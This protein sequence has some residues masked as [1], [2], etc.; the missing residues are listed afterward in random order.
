MNDYL[1][2]RLCAPCRTY[3]KALLERAIRDRLI[4]TAPAVSC[5]ASH[6][7]RVRL[8]P[9]DGAISREE[10]ALGIAGRRTRDIAILS[11]VGKQVCFHVLGQNADST[12]RLSRVSAQQEA[13]DHILQ[14]PAGTIV[15]AV[16]TGL[17]PFGAF[18]DIGCGVPA[19]LPLKNLCISRLSHPAALLHEGQK[20]YAALQTLDPA[21]RRVSISMKELLGT[22]QENAAR[23]A[24]GQ[25][26]LGI[27]RGIQDYGAFIALTPN[28]CGLTGPDPRLREGSAVSVYIRSID[29]ETLR[30]RL[31]VISV[32]DAPAQPQPLCFT[33]TH[34]RLTIWQYGNHAHAKCL[35]IF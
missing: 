21:R 15:P 1:P 12:Y 6:T 18:A 32:L 30:I 25:T 4:L 16:V 29:P 20:I 8:G 19:L 2:E 28:L 34:G 17:A 13:L 31:N 23:F 5:D 7:L 33:K 10:A 26:V 14:Q 27:V 11:C 22:W 9:F 24:P 35:T 3:D